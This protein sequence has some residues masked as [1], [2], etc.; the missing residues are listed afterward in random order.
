MEQLLKDISLFVN[1]KLIDAITAIDRSGY[2]GTAVIVDQDGKFL[3]II[4]DGDIRRALLKGF[5][6]QSPLSVVLDIK[7]SMP[8]PQALTGNASDERETHYQII[9]VNKI[10]QLPIIDVNGVCVNIIHINQF[11]VSDHKISDHTIVIFAGGFGKRLRPLTDTTPKPMLPVNGKPILEL[12]INRFKIYGFKNFIITTYYKSEVIT[13]YFKNGSN[14]GVN[15]EYVV[16]NKPL[17]TGGALRLIRELDKPFIVSN[18]DILTEINFEMFIKYHLNAKAD[19][20]V[21]SRT[22]EI[23]VPFGVLSND[24][25]KIRDVIEKPKHS[26]LVNAGMYVVNPQLIRKIPDN[27]EYNMTDL[28][29]DCIKDGLNVIAY[30]FIEEWIDVGRHND[31]N[32]INNNPTITY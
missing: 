4:T 13:E 16:E 23:E 22:H 30:P 12:I 9:I 10:K 6:L 3:E 21:A 27:E 14:H 15:I 25:N 19:L 1:D 31:Y 11:T 32:L 17:G 7:R 20:T 2:L 26:F 29:K 18:G 28:M 24:N 5:D 8:I